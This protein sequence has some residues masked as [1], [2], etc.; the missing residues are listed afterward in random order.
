MN[1]SDLL[2]ESAETTL[3]GAITNSQTSLVVTASAALTPPFRIWIG[4]EMMWVRARSGNTYSSIQRGFEGTGPEAHSSSDKVVFPIVRA[5][6]SLGAGAVF[7]LIAR[8]IA[9]SGTGGGVGGISPNFTPPV[10]ADYSWVNQGGASVDTS[11]GGIILIAPPNGPGTNS[12]RIR[13]KTIPSSPY[14][15]TTYIQGLLLPTG[16]QGQQYGILMRKSSTGELVTFALFCDS[17]TISGWA[18]QKWDSPT[19]FNSSYAGAVQR[20]SASSLYFRIQDDGVDRT[21]SI[22]VNGQ[23]FT[24]L[25]THARTDFITPDQIGFFANEVTNSWNCE[26]SVLHWLEET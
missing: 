3:N 26:M 12:L 1:L 25:L 14:T 17:A 23:T 24:E 8:G 18:I 22:S 5:G 16:T 6:N 15:L 9:G 21:F 2:N 10:D 20:I 4:S 19:V 7:E 13:V 11:F